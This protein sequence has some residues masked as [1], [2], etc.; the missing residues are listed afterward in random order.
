MK[1]QTFIFRSSNLFE[2]SKNMHY[3]FLNVRL[4]DLYNFKCLKV[5]EDLDFAM[6]TPC[7]KYFYTINEDH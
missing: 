7:S 5:I 1:K 2:I 6:F 4:C 3:A